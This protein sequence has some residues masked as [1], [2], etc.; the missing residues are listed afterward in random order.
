M[1]N[2]YPNNG[3]LKT[4]VVKVSGEERKVDAKIGHVHDDPRISDTVD[5]RSKALAK[6]GK[7][8]N[9]ESFDPA[10]TLV[11]PEM[12]I[13]IGP[14]RTTYGRK[15]KHD[16]VIVVP[17]FFCKE[18]D[19]S[20]YY[21]LVA[22]IREQQAAGADK[23][24]WISWHEGAHL[25]TNNP[26]GSKAYQQIQDKISAYFEIEHKSVGTR[27]NWYRDSKDWKPFHHD[28]AAFNPKV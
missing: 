26:K 25:I 13:V 23:S 9:T 14:N 24:E 10:S 11:R 20:L 22:E 12:R 6:K 3:A 21:Q 8:M 5:R 16:D 2:A 1:D 27:F 4:L 7:G 18:D 19:W 15:L 17:E 28:S